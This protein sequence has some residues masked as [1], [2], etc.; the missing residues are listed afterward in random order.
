[1]FDSRIPSKNRYLAAFLAFLFPGAG[2]FYQGRTFKA[3]IYAVCIFGTYT[4]GLAMAGWHGV[5]THKIQGAKTTRNFPFL[6]QT[7]V[8]VIGGLGWIQKQRYFAQSLDGNNNFPIEEGLNS[9]VTGSVVFHDSNGQIVQKVEGQILF[10]P[11]SLE[12]TLTTTIDGQA[13]TF[14]LGNPRS[15]APRIAADETWT[16]YANIQEEANGIARNVGSFEGEVPRSFT[17]WFCVPPEISTVDKWY[18]EYGGK[19]LDL[20]FVLTWIAGLLNFLVV[21]DA[22][23]GP[24][25]GYGDP[26]EESDNS[27]KNKK[28]QTKTPE[29]PASQTAPTSN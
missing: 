26:S 1:M 15:S 5:Y 17:N 7:G 19:R 28:P 12:G 16:M 4:Y 8:G 23:E 14:T 27:A 25:H 3:V 10:D 29:A 9:N 18:N 11:S 6:A 22:L 13:E 21:W 2:H 24:A 20:A